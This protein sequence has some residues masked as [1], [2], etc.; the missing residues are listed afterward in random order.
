MKPEK[1][2]V[3]IG[4]TSA[5]NI[6]IRYNILQA[7]PLSFK[8]RKEV[9]QDRRIEDAAQLNQQN[10]VTKYSFHVPTR[11]CFTTQTI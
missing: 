1:G 8:E 9:Y 6:F 3:P 7:S 10:R 11:V 4:D 2:C 5:R